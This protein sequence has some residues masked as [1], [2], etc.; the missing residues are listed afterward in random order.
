MDDAGAH[1]RP[2]LRNSRASAARRHGGLNRGSHD[3]A[4]L[5]E[6][7]CE[8]GVAAAV[9]LSRLGTGVTRQLEE[10][11]KLPGVVCTLR[12]KEISGNVWQC[13]G[14]DVAMM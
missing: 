12:D 7:L 1:E 4:V 13:G 11:P 3:L 2:S 9:R 5:E 10:I 6:G 8:R 14:N